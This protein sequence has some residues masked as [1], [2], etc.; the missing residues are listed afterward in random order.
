VRKLA[1]EGTV[2]RQLYVKFIEFAVDDFDKA[3][4]TCID[5]GNDRDSPK[6]RVFD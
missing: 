6:V 2:L 5:I 3:E 4:L 1:S